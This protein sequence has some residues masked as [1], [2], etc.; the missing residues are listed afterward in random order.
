[1]FG[2]VGVAG[3]G[4]APFTLHKDD[5]DVDKRAPATRTATAAAAAA[6]AE[7]DKLICSRGESNL[8]VSSGLFWPRADTIN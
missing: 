4:C 1:M 7:A 2:V 8:S 3:A 5:D 6:A